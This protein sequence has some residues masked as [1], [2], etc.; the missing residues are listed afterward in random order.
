MLSS[1]INRKNAM[2]SLIERLPLPV[3]FT[4]SI[5]AVLNGWRVWIEGAADLFGKLTAIVGLPIALC[6]LIYWWRKATAKRL[7]K[8]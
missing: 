8:D 2:I 3:A 6:M 1:L 4:T 7:E 5:L